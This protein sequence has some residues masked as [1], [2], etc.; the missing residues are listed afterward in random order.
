MGCNPLPLY[1][2]IYLLSYFWMFNTVSD[3]ASG[4]PFY[5]LPKPFD[6]P[7]LVSVLLHNKDFTLFFPWPRAEAPLPQELWLFSVENSTEKPR[8]VL[9]LCLVSS[10][11]TAS[12]PFFVSVWQ[13]VPLFGFEGFCSGNVSWKVS[14]GEVFGLSRYF[15]IS[16]NEKPCTSIAL[17]LF[18][19]L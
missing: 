4:R 1:L 13:H 6:L 11:A 2:F 5:L 15:C 3:L 9:E 17:G 8:F 19:I 18:V 14:Q 12:R 10:D 7:L 16:L